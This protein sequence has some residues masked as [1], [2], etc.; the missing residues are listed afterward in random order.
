[1]GGVAP[2]DAATNQ[3][4]TAA[5]GESEAQVSLALEETAPEASFK[6]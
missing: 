2:V 1:M 4:A 3:A 6:T 5:R